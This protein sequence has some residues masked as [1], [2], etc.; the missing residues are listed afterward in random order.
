MFN[1]PVSEVNKA[2]KTFQLPSVLPSPL[3]GPQPKVMV[4]LPGKL[5]L[6]PDGLILQSPLSAALNSVLFKATTL[7]A[8]KQITV[9]DTPIEALQ[10]LP[11]TQESNPN[12]SRTP[13]DPT[14]SAHSQYPQLHVPPAPANGLFLS[15]AQT[16]Q[17]PLNHRAF[18][19][20]SFPTLICFFV[21]FSPNDDV[22][23]SLSSFKAQRKHHLPDNTLFHYPHLKYSSGTFQPH[24]MSFTALVTYLYIFVYCFS[25]P[26]KRKLREN[27]DPVKF[28]TV[29]P[30]PEMVPGI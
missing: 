8:I 16:G 11:I 14:R 6:T 19:T 1:S 9:H 3:L 2:T 15:A 17:V 20:R 10:W 22:G 28:I 7:N 25:P 27:R 5:Q 21:F 18:C 26:P 24:F 29:S 4:S 30:V 23:G 13:V 12:L